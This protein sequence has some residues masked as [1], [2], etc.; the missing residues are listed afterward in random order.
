M[1][2]S[3]ITRI[4]GGALLFFGLALY[5]SC[6]KTFPGLILCSDCLSEEPQTAV[7][8]LK[9][10]LGSNSQIHIEVFE[11]NLNDGILYRSYSTASTLSNVTV[12]MNKKYTIA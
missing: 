11:G 10:S 4:F 6:E 9:L 2:L 5:F 12:I 1:V 7:L 3:R 8:E